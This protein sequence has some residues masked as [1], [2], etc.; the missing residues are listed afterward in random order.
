[1]KIQRLQD[2]RRA[3]SPA[4]AGV[5]LPRRRA[6]CRALCHVAAV[7]GAA[8][9]ALACTAPPE[10][11]PARIDAALASGD[12]A[13]VEALLTRASRPVFAAMQASAEPTGGAPFRIAAPKTPTELVQLQPGENAVVLT[14]R[15]GAMAKGGAMA[16]AGGASG[17][18]ATTREWV[19]VKEEGEWRLDLMAT[20]ARRPWL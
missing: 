19:V 6:Y 4:S 12:G 9:L 10:A 14:V 15:S 5:T 18:G 7:L 17:P 3:R 13:A 1:M 20:S 16:G 2:S 8:S 11:F